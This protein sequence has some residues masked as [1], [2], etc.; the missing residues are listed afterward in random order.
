[1]YRGSDNDPGDYPD[2]YYSGSD[3]DPGSGSNVDSSAGGV[4]FLKV[5]AGV[6]T[7][8]C[9]T[10]YLEDRDTGEAASP[11]NDTPARVIILQKSRENK[12]DTLATGKLSSA[13]NGDLQ[14]V[15]ERKARAFS[16]Q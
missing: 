1:M 4:G 14:I 12:F 8:F 7:L 9:L 6:V 10:A 5:M 2:Y 13:D 15:I 3:N 11:V 16:P